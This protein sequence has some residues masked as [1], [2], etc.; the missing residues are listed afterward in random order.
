MKTQLF[1]PGL[2]IAT[3]S[4]SYYENKKPEFHNEIVN[5]FERHISGDFG[6]ICDEDKLANLEDIKN[7]EGRILSRY[8][9]SEGD[10]YI[11]TQKEV[12]DFDEKGNPIFKTATRILFCNEY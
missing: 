8:K 1:K 12:F 10:I 7:N 3:K 6:I 5:C 9:T 4:I 2:I 11:N